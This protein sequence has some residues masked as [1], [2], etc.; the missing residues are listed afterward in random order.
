[1]DMKDERQT[2]SSVHIP[3]SVGMHESDN[4]TGTGHRYEF[5][6]EDIKKMFQ[7]E[8]E[9]LVAYR[10]KLIAEGKYKRCI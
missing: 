2:S 9:E 5:H 1:M 6:S 4:Y 7:M 3:N 8:D 10:D